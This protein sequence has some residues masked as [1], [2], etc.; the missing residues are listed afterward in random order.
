M[1]DLY[2]GHCLVY[3]VPFA[4][5]RRLVLALLVGC[6]CYLIYSL[7][8]FDVTKMTLTAGAGFV[9]AALA[10][11]WQRSLT[12]LW[13]RVAASSSCALI[14]F[15]CTAGITVVSSRWHHLTLLTAFMTA[16]VAGA[17]KMGV[18]YL[19]DPSKLKA[20]TLIRIRG[21]ACVIF[22]LCLLTHLNYHDMVRAFNIP[23][24]G[25]PH[26]LMNFCFCVRSSLLFCFYLAFAPPCR[27]YRNLPRPS[28]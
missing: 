25:M 17:S 3:N 24:A 12:T 18:S 2:P 10:C 23:T 6:C 16:V 20:D 28:C 11:Q 21:F 7:D 14:T 27:L 1:F 26:R 9:L 13:I 8:V 5:P 15:A 4:S 22:A 19:I